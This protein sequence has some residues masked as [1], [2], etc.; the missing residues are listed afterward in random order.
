MSNRICIH[1]TYFDHYPDRAYPQEER[2]LNLGLCKYPVP[3]WLKPIIGNRNYVNRN[4][5][6]CDSWTETPELAKLNYNFSD[7][8]KQE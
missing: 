6:N 2:D 5:T 7:C 4:Q 1:C 8:K 3:I